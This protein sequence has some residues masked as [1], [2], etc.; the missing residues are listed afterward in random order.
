MQKLLD[1]FDIEAEENEKVE[2]SILEEIL[3]RNH[4]GVF[5]VNFYLNE[6]ESKIF[7]GDFLEIIKNQGIIFDHLFS[8]NSSEE[9]A[10][11][12]ILDVSKIE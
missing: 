4:E 6:E 2:N 7:T 10:L 8:L 3:T 1:Q 9:I 11:R 5:V 12:R